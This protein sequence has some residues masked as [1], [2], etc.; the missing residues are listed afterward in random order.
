MKKIEGH[1]GKDFETTD[2]DR[3]G[4]LTGKNKYQHD[5][6]HGRTGMLKDHL[7]DRAFYG[8]EYRVSAIEN[9]N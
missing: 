6:G 4:E 8:G 5:P 1:L 7:V 2:H 9:P 3:S